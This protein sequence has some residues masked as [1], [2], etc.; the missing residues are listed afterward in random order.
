MDGNILFE[1]IFVIPLSYYKIAIYVNT[2]IC[3]IHYLKVKNT[4]VEYGVSISSDNFDP[5]HICAFCSDSG[6]LYYAH[7][8]IQSC[9]SII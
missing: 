8:A 2:F 1:F 3:I 6:M 5:A 7:I 9:S 4:H